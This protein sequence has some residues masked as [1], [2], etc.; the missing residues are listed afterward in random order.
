M[1]STL[2]NSLSTSRRKTGNLKWHN[3]PI[4]LLNTMREI[5]LIFSLCVLTLLST[6]GYWHQTSAGLFLVGQPKQEWN[7]TPQCLTQKR[8]SNPCFGC[9]GSFTVLWTIVTTCS[10]QLEPLKLVIMPTMI[11]S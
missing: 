7:K 8:S 2:G 10:R 11:I 1:R 3:L 9:W 5:A 6:Q 4:R